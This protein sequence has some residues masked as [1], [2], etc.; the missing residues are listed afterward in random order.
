[1]LWASLHPRILS[2]SLSFLILTGCQENEPTSGDNCP[3]FDI[4]NSPPFDSPIWHPTQ[5]IIGFNHT[6]LASIEF[7]Y[8]SICGGI[9]VFDQDSSGFWL[10]NTDGT[11]LRRILSNRLDSPTWSHDGQWIA[12]SANGNIY[13][14]KFS[15][16]ELHPDTTVQLTYSGSNSFPAWSPDDMWIAY[17]NVIGD[18]IGIWISPTNGSGVRNYFAFGG[19]PVWLDSTNIL[20]GNQ[21]LWIEDLQ[22]S[23][24][25]QILIEANRVITGPRVKNGRVF[26]ALGDSIYAVNVDGSNVEKIHSSSIEIDSGVPLSLSPDGAILCFTK[27][28]ARTH[29]MNN[30]T[31]WKH[32]LLTKLDTQLTVN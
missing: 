12:F 10:I 23:V 7:P 30:G 26:L 15:N 2:L 13:K 8:G 19:Q 20:Y 27:F 14:M 11:N 21:G 6:P 4:L 24:K 9:F 5:D 22:H 16:Q 28:N 31:I 1:M 17:S 3:P 32:D 18:S 29:D 25:S